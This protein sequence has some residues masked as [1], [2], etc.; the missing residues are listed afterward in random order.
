[1]EIGDWVLDEACRQMS[2]WYKDG[3]KNP[4]VAVNVCAIQ[5]MRPDFVEFVKHTCETHGV[6]YSYLELENAESV[7][8]NDVQRVINTCHRLRE[9]SIRVAIDDFGTGY[10]SL[11]YLYDLPVD[12]LKID[13]AFVTGLND[14]TSKS[15]ART[16]VRLAES[17]GLETVAE[18][19]GTVDQLEIIHE[20]GCDY[21]QGYHYSKPVFPEEFPESIM[22]INRVCVEQN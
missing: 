17:S 9:L 10:S 18:G 6:E 19:G 5:F 20:L 2:V 8:V 7:L 1:V 12:T 22:T 15:V 14:T 4:Q 11:S 3:L 13:R 16:N 21:M